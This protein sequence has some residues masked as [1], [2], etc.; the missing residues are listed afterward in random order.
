MD[1]DGPGVF[2]GELLKG[3]HHLRG[4]FSFELIPFVFAVFP[5]LFFNIVY[6]PV[7][8][9]DDHRAGGNVEDT[10]Q[11]TVYPAFAVRD[12]VVA[13]EHY[14]GV[15][16]EFERRLGWEA[17]PPEVVFDG[18][19]VGI[20]FPREVIEPAA[21]F[22]M[23][24]VVSCSQGNDKVT[25]VERCIG[26]VA[27]VQRA[28]ALVINRA[29][30][31]LVEEVDKVPV[32]LPVDGLEGMHVQLEGSEGRGVEEIMALVDAIKQLVMNGASGI[33]YRWKLKDIAHKNHLLAAKQPVLVASVVPQGVVDG[34]KDIRAKHRHFIDNDGVGV[35]KYPSA[36]RVG[37]KQGN[38]FILRE[39]RPQGEAEEGMDG[40]ASDIYGCKTGEC[41]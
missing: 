10:R 17:V 41:Q 18:C 37:L 2:E 5:E 33:G 23:R 36:W 39:Q 29:V 20:A 4:D 11:R 24:D 13:N 8:Q 35:F 21:V 26:V 12:G 31:Y 28:D 16:L 7:W 30:A 19:L 38:F 22:V 40:L 25:V 6:F 9:L 3:A 27:P 34:L 1:R 15:S 14:L 32:V